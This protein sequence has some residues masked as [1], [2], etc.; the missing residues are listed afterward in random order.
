MDN[1]L[2]L[3]EQCYVVG[4]MLQVQPTPDVLEAFVELYPPM[5]P[6]DTQSVEQDYLRLFVG[7]GTPLA[8]PWESAW[9]NDARLLFQRETLDV[10]YWYRSAG[11]QLARLHHDPDDHIGLELE[12]AGLL[13]ERGDAQTAAAFTREHPLAWVD[14]WADA[15]KEDARCGFYDVVAAAALALFQEV[16]P[17]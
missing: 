9:A 6:V 13:L 14:R 16:A 17:G 1:G 2:S 3:A 8:P 11:L 15:V 5:G 4:R 10:R 7:L 12:F